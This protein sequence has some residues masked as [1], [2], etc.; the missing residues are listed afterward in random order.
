M[1]IS[2]FSIDDQDCFDDVFVINLGF[3]CQRSFRVDFVVKNIFVKIEHS[4]MNTN[5][6]R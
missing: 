3:K 2:H 1:S 6:G 4:I 5:D